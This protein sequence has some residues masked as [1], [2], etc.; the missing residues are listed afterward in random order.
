MF[1]KTILALLFSYATAS[2][3]ALPF[4]SQHALVF[5]EESG[6]VLLEKDAYAVVPIASVTKLM[7]A[8]VVL[9]AKQD[10]EELITVE[11]ADVDVIKHSSSRVPVG[12]V[13]PRKAM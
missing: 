1:K 3:Y 13:L 9:D 6:R 7:T 5:E 8:M 4:S 12:V 11:Q 10:M 2:A